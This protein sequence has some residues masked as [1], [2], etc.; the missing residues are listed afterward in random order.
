[1]PGVAEEER[2]LNW[3]VALTVVLSGVVVILVGVAIASNRTDALSG[4]LINIGVAFVLVAALVVVERRL[5]RRVESVAESTAREVSTAQTSDLRSRVDALEELERNQ[6][7]ERQRRYREAD[8]A[9]ARVADSVT[10]ETLGELIRHGYADQLFDDGEYRVR[11]STRADCHVLYSVVLVEPSGVG[12]L[13]LGFDPIT[14]FQPVELGSGEWTQMPV[15]DGLTVIWRDDPAHDIAAQLEEAL[16]RNNRPL[17][18]FSLA[19]AIRQVGSGMRVM[20]AAR[21]APAG[22]PRRIEGRLRLLINDEWAITSYGLEAVHARNAYKLTVAPPTRG[23]IAATGGGGTP[24]LRIDGDA[25]TG[26]AWDEALAW[27]Q[28]RE[29]WTVKVA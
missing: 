6:Q 18:E 14:K 5:V 28:Q 21:G 3:Q 23:P 24:T 16:L 29:G 19:Q 11:T 17:N 2:R 22:D 10:H 20:R 15:N 9:V 1:M 12:F 27:V 7:S 8:D 13:W 25:P 26:P 4:V